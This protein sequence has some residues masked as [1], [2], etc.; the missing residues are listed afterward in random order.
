MKRIRV[1]L[2]DDHAL[3]RAGVRSLLEKVPEVEV[4]A[5]ASDAREALALLE[6]LRPDVVIMDLAMPNMNGLEGAARVAR[7]HPGVRVLILSMHT[8]EEHVLQAIRAG[9]TGYLPKEAV[10]T[11]L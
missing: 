9:A 8:D 10:P 6:R 5:E 7:E 1:L 3:I 4:L 11:E 2:A